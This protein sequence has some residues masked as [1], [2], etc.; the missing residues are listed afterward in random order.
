MKTAFCKQITDRDKTMEIYDKNNY[1]E[2][3]I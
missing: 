3:H 1:K 2:K